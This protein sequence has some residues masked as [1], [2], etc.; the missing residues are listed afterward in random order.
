MP[1]GV[2][3]EVPAAIGDISL[4]GSARERDP[5]R[6]IPTLRKLREVLRRKN[7]EQGV[8]DVKVR[9]MQDDAI[10]LVRFIFS[11]SICGPRAAH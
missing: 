10:L 7:G 2:Q 6:A 3:S 1:L 11:N 5:G 8:Q 9:W 4:D